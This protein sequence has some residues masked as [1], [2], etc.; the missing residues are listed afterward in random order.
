MS[1]QVALKRLYAAS[2]DKL[3]LVFYDKAIERERREEQIWEQK[4]R[5]AEA[6]AERERIMA[7]RERFIAEAKA[8]QER[9]IADYKAKA[10][11]ARKQ[12]A[13]Y[14]LIWRR[15]I[16]QVSA[17]IAAAQPVVAL[18]P[19]GKKNGAVVAAPD[20]RVYAP[21][22]S[23]KKKISPRGVVGDAKRAAD[24]DANLAALAAA[25]EK[26]RVAA[27]ADAAV[28]EARA[29]ACRLAREIGGC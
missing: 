28:R 27:A 5:F 26:K 10:K 25:T 29:D 6:K 12:R 2:P 4:G 15:A 3:D 9:I 20:T 11:A 7:E 22:L 24:R 17:D 21:K 1:W 8:E 13:R 19:K 18:P 14:L 23:C 16:K